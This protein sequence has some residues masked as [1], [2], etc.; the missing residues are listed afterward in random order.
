HAQARNAIERIFGAFKKRFRI[1][2]L[3]SEFSM[4][5]QARLPAALAAIHNFIRLHDLEEGDLDGSLEDFNDY[6]EDRTRT[7]DAVGRQDPPENLLTD[8]NDPAQIRR[9]RIA[10][11][12]WE[13]YSM[14]LQER[15]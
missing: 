10:Q 9:A 15:G 12:M 7:F 1:L 14:V 11:S 2:H 4:H 3:G 6:Y 5:I 13:D 8:V